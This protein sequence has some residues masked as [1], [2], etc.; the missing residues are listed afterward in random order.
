MASP[1]LKPAKPAKGWSW[2][3]VGDNVRIGEV[4]GDVVVVLVWGDWT[5]ASDERV[6]EKTVRSFWRDR[7][8]ERRPEGIVV[9]A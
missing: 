2:E 4:D 9:F 6:D 3:G 8:G 5:V 7:A 1:K